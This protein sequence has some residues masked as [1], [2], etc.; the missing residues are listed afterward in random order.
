MDKSDLS[1]TRVPTLP[2][3]P[4]DDRQRDEDVERAEGVDAI[5][6]GQEL[7][8]GE[9]ADGVDHEGED[10]RDRD[11]E[12]RDLEPSAQCLGICEE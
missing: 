7:G 9:E 10:N 12:G 3:A 6:D 5:G 4:E 1:R 2:P 11:V 8:A